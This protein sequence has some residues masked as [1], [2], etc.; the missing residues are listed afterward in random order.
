[1][2]QPPL[3]FLSFILSLASSAQVH[4]GLIPDPTWGKMEKKIELAKQTIDLLGL[5]EEKTK[6]N[7]TEEEERILKE[8]LHNLRMQF[9]E[10]SKHEKIS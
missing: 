8:V 2:A 5:L 4:L 6:G 9:V 3:D 7:L 1:M 10:E